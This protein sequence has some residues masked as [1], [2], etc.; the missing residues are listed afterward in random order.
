MA[1]E[2]TTLTFESEEARMR[3]LSELPEAPPAGTQDVDAWMSEIEDKER[4]ISEAQIVQSQRSESEAETG[5]QPPAPPPSQVEQPPA[6]QSEEDIINFG[7]F[8][9]SELPEDLRKYKEPKQMIEQMAHARRY[10]NETEQ[11]IREAN[12]RI[13]ELES[14]AS[15][16]TELEQSIRKLEEERNKLQSR[17]DTTP[18]SFQQQQ[19]TQE[20]IDSLSTSIAALKDMDDMDNVYVKDVRDLLGK[21]AK[22][23]TNTRSLL[24]NTETNF[25]TFK[26]HAES[27]INGLESKLNSYL[28]T[29]ESEAKKLQQKRAAEAAQNGVRSLQEKYPELKTSKSLAGDNSVESSILQFCDKLNDGPVPNWD[30]ANRIINAYLRD[31]AQVTSLCQAKGV[32]PDDFGITKNDIKN[33]ALLTNVDAH[34]R[35]YEIDPNTGQYRKLTDVFGKPVTFPD[36]ESAYNHLLDKYG[37][38]EKEHQRR[39]VEAEKR[40]MQSLEDAMSRRDTSPETLGNAGSGSPDN[41]GQE[42]SQEQAEEILGV[43]RGARTIDEFRMETT[44]RAGDR[45]LFRLYQKAQKR[46]GIEP[47]LPEPTWPPENVPDK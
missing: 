5:E 9:R 25:S 39:L 16:A 24:K 42:L 47:D 28:S 31:D 41:V 21:A 10:A 44:A 33:Y 17:S 14:K 45:R 32:N 37:I 3:A 43:R 1:E 18:Q 6:S 8:K 4:Q 27:K 38:R 40:G 29:Q 22:E 7:Q 34:R 23:I 30:M 20:Q 11:R 46:L 2:T 35:G 26:S 19:A 13:A 36:H 12:T 15:K